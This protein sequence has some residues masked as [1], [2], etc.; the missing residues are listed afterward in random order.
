MS[1]ADHYAVIGN[2]VAHSLSPTIHRWFAEQTGERLE[3][4]RLFAELGRFSETVDQFR[5]EKAGKGLN[6]TVPF[7]LEAFEYA[8]VHSQRA[9]AAG[10][11]NCLKFDSDQVLGDNTDGIGLVDDLQGR[12]GFD[13][14]DKSVLL[15]GAGG[16]SRGVLKPLLDS[17][18]SRILICNRSVEKAQQ[19]VGHF[20]DSR[21]SALGF[22]ELQLGREDS[23]H[24]VINAT[25]NGLSAETLPVPVSLFKG[26]LLAYD[27]FYAAGPTAFLRQALDSGCRTVTDGLGMLV[28]QAAESFQIWRG[29]R[30][31]TAPVYRRLREQLDRQAR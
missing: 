28:E 4:D 18:V 10:A 17:G 16:A 23:Q 20:A 19:L 29:V 13:L 30:P 25:S 12:L 11:V 14:K 24:I 3:Y 31:L 27:M 7:K 2:P 26:A 9:I 22:A 15:L 21:L 6:V 5:R 1:L 8:M